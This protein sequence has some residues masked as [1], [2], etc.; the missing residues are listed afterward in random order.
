[1]E[2]I[3]DYV[4]TTYSHTSLPITHDEDQMQ[5]AEKDTDHSH[6]QNKLLR[7]TK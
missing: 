5:H 4:R 2:H 1:M 3:A 6:Y 7:H